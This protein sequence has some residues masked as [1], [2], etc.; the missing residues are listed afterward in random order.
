[1]LVRRL[2]R[3]QNG[4]L[5]YACARVTIS[6]PWFPYKKLGLHPMAMIC[7]KDERQEV[8]ALPPQLAL[9]A[10]QSLTFQVYTSQGLRLHCCIRGSSTLMCAQADCSVA[11]VSLALAMHTTCRVVVPPPHLAEQALQGVYS[12]WGSLQPKPLWHHILC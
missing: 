7:S 1:M 2:K 9:H 3:E 8:V 6:M 5:Q 4:Q 12:Q 10:P 11:E